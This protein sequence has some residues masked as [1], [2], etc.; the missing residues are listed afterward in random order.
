M[1]SSAVRRACGY[2]QPS[3]NLQTDSDGDPL[4]MLVLF[5]TSTGRLPALRSINGLPVSSSASS[6][7]AMIRYRW[8]TAATIA[9]GVITTTMMT[10]IPGNGDLKISVGRERVVM[11][12]HPLLRVWGLRVRAL[13]RYSPPL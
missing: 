8:R 2:A 3:I 7:M 9:F 10:M 12:G 6:A 1:R 13:V 4:T 11:F 5:V